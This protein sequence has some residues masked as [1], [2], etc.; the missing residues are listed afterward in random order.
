MKRTCGQGSISRRNGRRA[1][2]RDSGELVS[3][4]TTRVRWCRER[5]VN[6]RRR[7]RQRMRT[8]RYRLPRGRWI[9]LAVLSG[10]DLL[11]CRCSWYLLVISIPVISSSCVALFAYLWC[12]RIC[13]GRQTME[14]INIYHACGFKKDAMLF[15]H[16]HVL[17]VVGQL[18]DL[19]RSILTYSLS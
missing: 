6:T 14:L 8:A 1:H 19:T 10:W 5:L 15:P 4:R 13:V 2:E 9:L 18:P 12:D 11:L 16:P 3:H 17:C 7:H